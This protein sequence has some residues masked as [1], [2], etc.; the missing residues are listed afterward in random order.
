M[1]IS[2]IINVTDKSR[3]EAYGKTLN[4]VQVIRLI[5]QLSSLDQKEQEKG[6]F[7]FS[8]LSLEVF[9][10]V[11]AAASKTQI[12]FL[13]HESM[14]EPMQHQLTLFAKEAKHQMEVLF[15][16]ISSLENEINA[17]DMNNLGIEDVEPYQ[18]S[19]E[20]LADEHEALLQAVDNGL[21]IVWNIDRPDLLEKLSDVKERLS[22]SLNAA[23]GHGQENPTGL[24]HLL[25]KNM[26][27]NIDKNLSDDDPAIEALALFGI[28]SVEDFT[29]FGLVSNGNNEEEGLTEAKET[30]KDLGLA[31]VKDLKDAYIFS[32]K[33]LQE[34]LALD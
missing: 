31:T 32:K 10:Q 22:H 21:K 27:L 13:K 8:G 15:K 18:S 4:A 12:E 29:E 3:L 33:S 25:E 17:L 2:E 1:D 24:Y 16:S 19:I 20:E 9:F 6:A 30:L 26:F 23:I 7:L 11:L 34:Y 5:Q 28:K 14:L